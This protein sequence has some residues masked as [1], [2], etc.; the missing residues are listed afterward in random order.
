MRFFYKFQQLATVDR[1]SLTTGII[2]RLV[3]FAKRTDTGPRSFSGTAQIEVEEGF[4]F[5]L[6][7]GGSNFESDSTLNGTLT[8]TNFLF[9]YCRVV[10]R[11][12]EKRQSGLDCVLSVYES[13]MV[14]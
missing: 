10:K 11:V 7:A 2:Q 12:F 13:S 3:D 8:I 14:S 4:E 6:V 9:S 5:G 1:Y